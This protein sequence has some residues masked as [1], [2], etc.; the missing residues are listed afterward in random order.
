M[1]DLLDNL[2]KITEVPNSKN[3]GTFLG[4]MIG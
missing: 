2:D 1:R 4:F 3:A